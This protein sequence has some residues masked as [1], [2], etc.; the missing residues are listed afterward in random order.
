[1]ITTPTRL[2][3]HKHTHP[4]SD[5]RVNAETNEAQ[6]VGVVEIKQHPSLVLEGKQRALPRWVDDRLDGG[7]DLEVTHGDPGTL[8]QTLAA[9][10]KESHLNNI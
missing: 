4:Q 8:D 9:L 6:D 3:T 7:I 1:M 2:P 5:T 10:A